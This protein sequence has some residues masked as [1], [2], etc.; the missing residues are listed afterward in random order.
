MLTIAFLALCEAPAMTPASKA[1]V[2]ELTLAWKPRASAD[3]QILSVRVVLPAGWYINSAAPLDSF[4][5][6]TRVEADAA[7]GFAG[8]LLEFDPP[9]Y[10][11]AVVEHSE[12]LSGNMSLYKGT[13]EVTLTARGPLRGKKRAALPHPPPP[14]DVTLYYQSCDGTMCW[15]PKEVSARLVDATPPGGNKD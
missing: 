6:P 10:P 7:P 8:P 11:P 2:P 14:V 1:P 4:L 3:S 5:V 9:R 13:F 15:P 12:A